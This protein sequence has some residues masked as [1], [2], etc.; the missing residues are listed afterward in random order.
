MYQ[1]E[2]KKPYYQQDLLDRAIDEFSRGDGGISQKDINRVK[3]AAQVQAGIDRYRTEAKGMSLNDLR[4]EAH[5]SSRLAK[6]LEDE[7]KKRPDKC[8]AHAIVAGKH[9]HAAALR[10]IMA[11]LKIRIDDTDNGCWLP[12]NTAATPHPAFPKAVPH[13][14][15]H[16]YNYFFWIRSRLQSMRDPNMFRLDLRLIGQRLQERNIPEYV[17]MKKGEG[18]PGD[19]GAKRLA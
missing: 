13:S 2:V 18:L 11:R 9:E 6:H 5:D 16:R 12:E 1:R 8:H 3:V 10:A 15:I 7:G 17:M 14:R 19:V 4:D